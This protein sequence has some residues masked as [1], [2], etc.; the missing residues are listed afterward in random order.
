MIG[1]NSNNLY[2]ISAVALEN[3]I[4]R[5]KSCWLQSISFDQK[6]SRIRKKQRKMNKKKGLNFLKLV[7][8]FD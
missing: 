7:K 1:N 6:Q 2:T 3:Q 8:N 4:S 5:G